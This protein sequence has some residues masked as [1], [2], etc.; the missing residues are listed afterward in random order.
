MGSLCVEDIKCSF[1]PIPTTVKKIL[2]KYEDVML[3]EIELVSGSK[4]PTHAP[5]RLSQPELAEPRRQM[6][7]M[8]DS[9]IIVP[10]KSPY[11]SPVFF[12][13]KHEGTLRIYV[14]YRALN[15]NIVKNKYPIS[16]MV[17]LF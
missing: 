4:P 8:L 9:E 16:L 12:E 2:V 5:Y 11:G 6:T 7:K 17:D 1:N 15:K 10:S 13:K 14:D 3:Q